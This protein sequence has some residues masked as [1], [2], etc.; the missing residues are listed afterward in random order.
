[1]RREK[2][3]RGFGGGRIASLLGGI[4]EGIQ[5]LLEVPQPLTTGR[6]PRQ[7]KATAPK[8]MNNIDFRPINK[9]ALLFCC[10]LSAAII[11]SLTATRA[12]ADD[13]GISKGDTSKF[14]IALSNSYAGNTWR[15]EMLKTWDIA[16]KYAIDHHIIAKTKVVNSNNSAPEQASQI[17][18]LIVEGW[19]AI[20][21]DAASD[22]ALNGVIKEATDAGIV[23]VVFDA[24]A[25]APSAYKVAYNYVS[26]GQQEAD[27]VAKRLNGK[28]NVLEIRG[29]AGTSVD[30][31]ISKG[32]H[33]GFTKYP[34]IK[35]VGSVHGNW[36]Q[37]IAQKEVAGILPTLPPVDAV[38]T[39]G[40][41]GWGA[42]EAFKEAGRKIPLIIMGH[43]QDELALWKQL[44]QE[45]G[46]YETFSISSAPGCASAAFWVAQQILAGKK[47][48]MTIELPLPVIEQ[49]DF[50]AWLKV[51]P[52]GGV[53]TPV[54]GQEWTAEVIDANA[55]HKPL[56]KS[57][58]PS[59]PSFVAP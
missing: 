37:T 11:C 21:I 55:E 28:G 49:S 24:L 45:P 30:N 25:T 54:F 51:L 53:A 17:E 43:R 15:Q 10:A 58:S 47:V 7:N 48:P 38:V 1:V 56:P 52:P 44:S 29:V 32:T 9:I 57:P 42:Y 41:D 40:G 34:D 31:D 13:T 26:M 6:G 22:T 5:W 18:N 35:I 36:T 16:S 19:K 20:V 50:D 39:Q 33:D 8:T 3:A 46:G 23:V 14:G 2:S 59:D 12:W 4:P 27:Y